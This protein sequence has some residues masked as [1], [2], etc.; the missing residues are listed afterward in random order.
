MQLYESVRDLRGAAR[1]RRLRGW[2]IYQMGPLDEAREATA[3]AL[4]ALRAC[5]DTW[6]VAHC[7]N[8]LAYI[9][10]ERG[11]LNVAREFMRRR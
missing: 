3:V 11:D 8:Q 6:G 4:V 5:G 2:A 9:E 1:A 10:S 7:L